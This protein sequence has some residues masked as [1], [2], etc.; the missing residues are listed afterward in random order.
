MKPITIN[1]LV[2]WHLEQSKKRENTQEDMLF[3]VRAI[4]LLSG[5]VSAVY[6]LSKTIQGEM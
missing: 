4:S 5:M 1:E 6:T 3:H 2:E